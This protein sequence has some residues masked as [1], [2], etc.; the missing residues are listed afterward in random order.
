M[1]EKISKMQF[2]LIG[3]TAILIAAKFDVIFKSKY[4]FYLKNQ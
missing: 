1:R 3:A 4:N 2:Q